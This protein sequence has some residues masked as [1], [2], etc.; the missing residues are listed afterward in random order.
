[1]KLTR[2]RPGETRGRPSPYIEVIETAFARNNSIQC[3]TVKEARAVRQC[4]HRAGYDAKRR[5]KIVTLIGKK[6]R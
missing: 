6:G 1:M 5:D 3:E 2:K 4:A